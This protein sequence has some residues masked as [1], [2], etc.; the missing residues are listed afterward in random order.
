MVNN[1]NSVEFKINNKVLEF[2]IANH[3]KYNFFKDENN[4]P[5]EIIF[6]EEQILTKI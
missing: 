3:S 2:M 1:L 5:E 4:T 6:I